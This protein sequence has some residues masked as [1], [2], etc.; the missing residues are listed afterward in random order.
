MMSYLLL[1]YATWKCKV[2]P[3]SNS[4]TF[5]PRGLSDLFQATSIIKASIAGKEAEL[6]LELLIWALASKRVPT[7]VCRSM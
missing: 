5:L 6:V 3:A 2:Y 4:G 1:P 7:R